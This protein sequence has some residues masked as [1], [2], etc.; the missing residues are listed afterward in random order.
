MAK[1]KVL[2]NEKAHQVSVQDGSNVAKRKSSVKSRSPEDPTSLQ[3]AVK[4]RTTP[5]TVRPVVRIKPRATE[6]PAPPQPVRAETPPR[7][8]PNRTPTPTAETL[9]ASNEVVLQ[10]LHAL[11]DRN[12]FVAAQLDRLDASKQ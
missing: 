6:I 8:A 3:P 9:W 1:P 12:A 10:R 7:P 4:T 5:S 2:R 11:K